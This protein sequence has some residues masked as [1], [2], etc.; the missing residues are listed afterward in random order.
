MTGDTRI[1]ELL[2]EIL[3]SNLPP[4]VVCAHCPELL[5]EVK[6]RLRWLRHVDDQ[7]EEILPSTCSGGPGESGIGAGT[8]S[9]E[10]GLP[11]IEGYDVERLLGYGGMGVVYRARHLKLKRTVALKMLLAGAY[12][13]RQDLVRFQREAEAVAALR[14]PNIVQIFGVGDLHGRPYFTMEL[15][16]GGSLA[17]SLAGAPQPARSGVALVEA[18]AQA[19]QVAHNEGI[20]HRDLKPANVLLTADGTPKITD[21][22]LARRLESDENLTFSGA[23]VGTPSYMAPEQAAGN[24]GEVGPATDV[25]ALG[26]IL[27]EMLTGRPPFR[28]ETPSETERQVIA[29]EPAAPSRLNARIPRDIETICLKCLSKDPQRRYTTAAAL[30]D[31]LQRFQR[32]DPISARRPGSWERVRRWLRRH[33]SFAAFVGISVLFAALLASAMVWLGVQQSRRRHAIEADLQ[34]INRLQQQ[35][36]WNDAEVAIQ[37]AEAR[38]N[39]GGN[40]DLRQRLE[41]VRSDLELVV[42]L[43]HIR[44]KRETSGGDL[45]YYR[46]TADRQ[47]L[48][49]FENSRLTNSRDSAGTVAK[50]VNASAVRIALVAALDDWAVCARD[51]SRR[52]WLLTIAR[53]A[54]PDPL[55]W[56]DR[57]RDSATWNDLTALTKLAEIVPV[58]KQSISLLLALGERLSAAG[59]N[60]TAFLKRVQNEHPGDFWTNIV[61]GDALFNTSPVEATGYYRAALASR[62]DAPVAYTALGD[63]LRL[64]KRYDEAIGYYQEAL[65]IDP[66]YARGH[67][68]LGN[69]LRDAN[70]IDDA[71]AS[72]RRS[73]EIDP[74]YAWGHL[75]LANA[76]NDSNRRDESLEH[77]RRFLANGPFVAHIANILRSDLISHGRGEEARVDWKKALQLDPPSHD[78]W[79]GYAELC[80]FLEN[81]DE[82]R[83]ARKELI[84]KFGDTNDQFVSEK[85]ARAI[86]LAPPSEEELQTATALVDR[87][88]AAKSNT[89]EWIFPYFLFAKGLAEYRQGNFESAISIMTNAAAEVMGPCPRLIVA[90]AKYGQGHE[91]EAK[92]N[93]AEATRDIDWS[94][95]GVRSHD[96]WIWHVLRREAETMIFAKAAAL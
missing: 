79:F 2:E 49:T 1:Q 18:L 55:G 66:N 11:Q 31:D 87:A 52:E 47:Y 78:E 57:I 89:P 82:Y 72:Y 96:Q 64:Q 50:R 85:I 91:Q 69:F 59:G 86:L 68:N 48:S 39:E 35:A 5:P 90:M 44:L 77:Y 7:L 15:L 34:E 40:G 51:E 29:E 4:E 62:P 13:R 9:P 54:D 37:R 80:L 32:G 10:S 19:V 41:Q 23:R 58:K 53:E 70:R 20:V 42:Q 63:S 84:R 17:Q 30:I 43:D 16:E 65:Q 60:A 12:A 38:L 21:F 73:I 25:Y 83:L 33:P 8:K 36:L 22:G 74:N 93:F 67:T 76:L 14:H 94:V 28:A 88:V 6:K 26:A 27:Y 81:E 61:L 71:I 92:A 75:G 95:D 46:T 24:S 56:R 45:A 3:D